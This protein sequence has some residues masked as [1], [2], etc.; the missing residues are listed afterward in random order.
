MHRIKLGIRVTVLTGILCA[1]CGKQNA[2]GERETPSGPEADTPAIVYTV[3]YPL[4]YLA[5]GIGGD[6]LQVTFPAPGD[7][8]PACWT[9][10]EETIAGYQKADLILLNGADYAKWVP[11]TSLANSRMVD[12]S[13]GFRDE[14]IILEEATTHSHGP[15][16]KH[17]HG[18]TAFT[19]WLDLSLCAEQAA[20]IRD[21][22]LRRWPDSKGVFSTNCERMISD[23][24]ALDEQLLS[25]CGDHSN[26]PLVVSHPVYQYFTRRYHLN[27]RSV[28]W[29]P[30]EYPGEELWQEFEELLKEHSAK[31]MVWEG[32]PGKEV[33]AKLA[34]LGVRSVVF[35]PCGNRP[36]TGDFVSVMHRNIA[37][38][39][40]A[41]GRTE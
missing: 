13:A 26:T 37:N 23:L 18:T 31:L 27:V 14:Y 6:A 11:K 28:H 24:N 32:E 7:E 12:T 9:P 29:E 10:D 8:D 21:A 41:L 38:L 34:E 40:Q 39:R 3:N 25:I 19:T 22:F 16:G 36:D 2:D 17:E 15:G 4:A 33:V 1:G 35:D 20:A 30:D 5:E